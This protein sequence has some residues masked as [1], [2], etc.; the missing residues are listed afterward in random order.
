MSPPSRVVYSPNA[1][2][3]PSVTGPGSPAAPSPPIIASDHSYSVRRMPGSSP[4]SSEI[5]MSGM[6]IARSDTKS[7]SPDDSTSSITELVSSRTWS[8][9]ERTWRGVNPFDRSR[10]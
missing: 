6:C 5:T 4:S 10:R 1:I 2:A 8:V 3:A 7:I 9:I